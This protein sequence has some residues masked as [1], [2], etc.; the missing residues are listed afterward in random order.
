MGFY[1]LAAACVAVL[2][3]ASGAIGYSKGSASRNQE[4]AEQGAALTTSRMLAKA[5]E[6][7]NAKVVEREVIIYKDRVRVIKE[8]EPGEIQL[9]E[10]I[11]RESLPDLSPTFR[12]LHDSAASGSRPPE[13]GPGA[14]D[15]PVP[16]EVVAETI[17]QNYEACRTDQGKLAALQEIIR[18]Q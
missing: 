9:V 1:G 5:A 11:R 3:I 13:S 10:V 4:I 7:R 6:A 18:S 2:C 16:V 14:N 12:L 15:P 17:R 8:K